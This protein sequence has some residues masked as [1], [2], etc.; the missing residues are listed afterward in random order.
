M[1]TMECF[2][3]QKGHMSPNSDMVQNWTTK[4]L[5]HMGQV[6]ASGVDKMAIP[7][8]F[9]EVYKMKGVQ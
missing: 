6:I 1:Y 5:V 7:R 2:P 4:D 3:L 8:Q 9:L